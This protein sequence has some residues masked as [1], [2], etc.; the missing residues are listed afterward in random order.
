MRYLLIMLVA[1]LPL[2]ADAVEFDENTRTLPLG[3]AVQVFEDVTGEA[4][5]EEVS[6]PALQVRFRDQNADAL[7]AGYSRSAYWLKVELQFRPKQLDA[8]PDWLLEMAYPPMDHV[9]LY[10][11]DASGR[12]RLAWQ[13]GDMLPFSSRQIKQNNFLFD[14]NLPPDEVKTLYVRVAGHGSIQAPLALWSSHAYIEAQPARIYV[15][16]LI[17]GMLMGMLVYNLFIYVGVRD[18]SYLYYILYISSFGL[19]QISVNGAGIEFF[20]PENPWWANA[21]TPFLVGSAVFFASQFSRHFLQTPSLNRWLD[22]SLL[23]LMAFAAAVMVLSITVDYGVALRLATGLVLLFTLV[24]VATGIT[25][26]IRGLRVARYYIVAWSLFLTGGL[27]N[28]FMLM[29]YLPNNFFTMYSSQIGSVLEVAL[30]SLALA[31]RINMMREQQAQI[32]LEAGQ[33]LERVNQ[34]LATSNRL[35]DE[36][37]ATLTHELRTPMNGV[38]GSLELMQML[39]MDSE[40]SLYQQTAADSAQDMMGMVNGILTLT[41]LQAGKLYAVNEP[42]SLRRLMAD[43]RRQYVGAAQVKHLSFVI[44]LDDSLPDSLLGDVSKLQQCMGCLL[45]NAIKFT[46]A[47]SVILKITGKS[48]NQQRYSVR[49]DVIDSGIGFSRLDEAAL[50]QTF[51]QVDSSMTREYGG[52][53]IGLAICRQLIELVGGTLSHQS[54]PGRGSCFTLR[55]ELCRSE[56]ESQRCTS[57]IHTI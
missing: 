5:I 6:D 43:L 57:V 11:A 48:D 42:F 4:T 33:N 51:F 34:Q 25:A 28:A 38:I 36:F 8:R 18:T 16:G 56:V 49:I 45:D 31:D 2:L 27:I 32:V 40:L 20:W 44:E 30:L 46:K 23:L 35:K 22:R 47:G 37:L 55:L 53:G 12:F 7:N 29:G 21:S 41:Q 26:K 13:T 3:R 14:L 54:E 50:Y 24:I 15:L 9:D 1:W 17:Y 52:L 39:P 10:T 19:Y